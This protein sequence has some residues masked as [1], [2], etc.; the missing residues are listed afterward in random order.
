ML[1]SQDTIQP[2]KLVK[3]TIPLYIYIPPHL[4]LY[5]I[6]TWSNYFITR[7]HNCCQQP[8]LL[9]FCIIHHCYEECFVWSEVCG[10]SVG[11]QCGKQI[12]WNYFGIVMGQTDFLVVLKEEKSDECIGPPAMKIPDLHG[13]HSSGITHKAPNKT[14]P[15]GLVVYYFILLRDLLHSKCSCHC[16]INTG[17]IWNGYIE[18]RKKRHLGKGDSIV[19]YIYLFYNTFW[20]Y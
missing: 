7:R 13:M 16:F 3:T 18:E 14:N 4:R 12:D 9:I 11:R 15:K 6:L 17:M 8:Q 19:F 2:S 20:Y 5:Y 1:N 10:R